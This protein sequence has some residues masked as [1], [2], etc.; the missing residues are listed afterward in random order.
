MVVL[1]AAVAANHGQDAPERAPAACARCNQAQ[2]EG[3]DHERG[4]EAQPGVKLLWQ[5][6]TRSEQG[7]QPYRQNPDGMR[8]G[9]GQTERQRLPGRALHSH[10]VSRYERLAVARLQ[11]VDGAEPERQEKR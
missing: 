7:D 9:D 10:E 5:N 3:E 6:E 1:V 2:A 4:S 8:Y 11:R